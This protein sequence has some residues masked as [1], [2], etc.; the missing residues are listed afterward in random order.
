MVLQEV[1][2]RMAADSTIMALR[3]RT[4]YAISK[5]QVQKSLTLC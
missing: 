4:A 3:R 2:P 5:M 1:L